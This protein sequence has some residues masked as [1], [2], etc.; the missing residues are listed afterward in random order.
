[1]REESKRAAEVQAI[2]ASH[3]PPPPPPSPPEPVSYLKKKEMQKM[4]KRDLVD[5]YTRKPTAKVKARILAIKH[6]VAKLP[7]RP[8]HY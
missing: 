5:D 6:G 7:P 1:M 2:V 3:A 4:V 8:V